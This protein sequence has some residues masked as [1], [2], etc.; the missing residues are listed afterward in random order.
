MKPSASRLCFS[1][2]VFLAF[3]GAP[4]Y[5]DP[6][7]CAVLFTEDAALREAL[8]ERVRTLL[9]SGRGTLLFTNREAD[10]EPFFRK[11]DLGRENTGTPFRAKLGAFSAEL[12]FLPRGEKELHLRVNSLTRR[13]SAEE[14]SL[15][16]LELI[17]A[18]VAWLTKKRSEGVI[19]AVEVSAQDIRG[20][21]SHDFLESIGFSR[22]KDLYL[23]CAKIAAVGGAVGSG[24][25]YLVF[26]VDEAEVEGG[27]PEDQRRSFLKKTVGSG[28]AFTLGVATACIDRE[29]RSYRLRMELAEKL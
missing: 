20:T 5:A 18:Q 25:G 27:A 8:P 24:L 23:H 3:L 12:E 1:I 15:D 17:A 21:P 9:E 22:R 29:R 16:L 14:S 19:S 7:S 4:A 6:K 28:V 2:S 10:W 11:L 26:V 13:A